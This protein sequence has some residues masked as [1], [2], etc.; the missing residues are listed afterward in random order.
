M[1]NFKNNTPTPRTIPVKQPVT[2]DPTV[3]DPEARFRKM[4]FTTVQQPTAAMPTMPG[5]L[6]GLSNIELSDWQTKYTQWREYTQD[7]L[8]S[9]TKELT[10]AIEWYNR[11]YGLVLHTI[12][13]ENR[14][15]TK[16]NITEMKLLTENT[17][18]VMLKQKAVSD[19]ELLRDFLADKVKS[20]D[21]CLTV[22]SREITLRSA[23]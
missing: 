20:F 3:D 6:A 8:I 16:M 9:A 17:E 13:Q 11:E 5:S 14:K 12:R 21:D 1:P 15:G 22:I 2:H 23:K 18:S 10:I 7:R 19:A 4:G